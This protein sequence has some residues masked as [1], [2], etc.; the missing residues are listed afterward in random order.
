MHV[1]PPIWEGLGSEETSPQHLCRR[2]AS[3]ALGCTPVGTQHL[4]MARSFWKL[5]I[6]CHSA[7][8][9]GRGI[10]TLPHSTQPTL[11]FWG[12]ALRLSSGVRLC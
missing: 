10:G 1:L 6:G 2:S 9:P 4:Q 7:T 5:A 3:L 11:E 12:N 8:L